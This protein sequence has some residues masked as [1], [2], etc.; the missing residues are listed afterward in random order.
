VVPKWCLKLSSQSRGSQ[1]THG[2][3]ASVCY[4]SGDCFLIGLGG[5]EL[6]DQAIGGEAEGLR[7][8]HVTR[9]RP[10]WVDGGNDPLISDVV[11]STHEGCPRLDPCVRPTMP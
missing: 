7:A 8:R 9:N 11:N 6:N 1:E 3:Q 10:L 4:L 5:L 2:I